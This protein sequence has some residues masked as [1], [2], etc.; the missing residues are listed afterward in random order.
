MLELIKNDIMKFFI[1]NAIRMIKISIDVEKQ[2]IFLLKISIL[3]S[4]KE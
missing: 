1:H 3:F 4:T 2:R